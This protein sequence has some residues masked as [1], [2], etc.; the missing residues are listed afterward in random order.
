[1]D[2]TQ[3]FLSSDTLIATR[4]SKCLADI[5][6]WTTAHNLNLNLEQTELLFVPGK[7]FPHMDLW[8][9]L[10]TLRYVLHK[11]RGTSAWYWTISYATRPTAVAQSCRFALYNISRIQPFLLREAAQL[12]ILALVISH[13]D[14]SNSPLPLRL[15]LCSV[16]RMWQHALC[17][18]YQNSPCDPPLP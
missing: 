16:S 8:S 13:L 2:D 14:Y 4:I 9:L 10:R 12:L 15:N 6:T 5:S 18:T 17:S 11:P 1:M 3:L 7:D